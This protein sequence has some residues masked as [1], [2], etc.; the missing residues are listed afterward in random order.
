M[1]FSRVQERVREGSGW[2]S[3]D[4]VTTAKINEFINHVYKNKLPDDVEW[5]DL[6]DWVYLDAVAST[7]KYPFN[8]H[9]L[10]AAAGNVV[11]TRIR[12][13]VPPALLLISADSTKRLGYTYDADGFWKLYP[14]HTNETGGQPV[15]LLE[16]GRDLWLRPIPN[17]SFTVQVW[18]NWRP[19]DL[20]AADDLIEDGWEEAVIAGTILAI[21]EDDEDSDG[22]AS[23]E[24]TYGRRIAEIIQRNQVHKPGRVRPHW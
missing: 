9:L 21:K 15:H 3:S 13:L 8:T 11:G 24:K 19:A 4:D 6:Q 23:W 5:K 14:P 1:I 18:A 2:S 16:R 17:D 20:S 7:G 22:V 10:D 12:S